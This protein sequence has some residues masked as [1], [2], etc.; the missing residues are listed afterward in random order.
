MAETKLRRTISQL[1]YA[2]IT[3]VDENGKPTYGSIVWLPHNEGGGREYTADPTGE[4]ASIWADGVEVYSAED[5]QGYDLKLTTLNVCDDIDEEWYGKTVN[6]DGS[7]EEYADGREYPHMAL[8][9]ME[10][11]TDGIGEVTIY[12]DAHITQRSSKSGK[13][14]EGSGLDPEFPEHTFACRPRQDC[15][16]VCITLKTKLKVETIPEPSAATP[17]ISIAESTATVAVGQDVQ[18]TVDSIYPIGTTITWTSGTT[19]KATVNSSGKVH[20]AAAGESTITASITVGGVQYTDTC[21]VTVT[22]T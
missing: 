14:S 1:G 20:G 22:S 21:T 13:T 6:L 18:L 2:P 19:A 15:K 4:T 12:Y 8:I 17:H 5:N 11:T 7:V 3:S 9:I 10:D 16:C